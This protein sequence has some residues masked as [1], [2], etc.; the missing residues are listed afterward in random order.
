MSKNSRIQKINI[1]GEGKVGFTAIDAED[2]VAFV[3]GSRVDTDSII[4]ATT[5][6]TTLQ[7]SADSTIPLNLDFANGP[8]LKTEA[9]YIKYYTSTS[10]PTNNDDID[11]FFQIGCHWYNKTTDRMFYCADNRSDIAAWKP[12]RKTFSGS[13]DPNTVVT[14]YL[15]DDYY[16]TVGL[17]WYKCISA[18]SG[19]NWVAT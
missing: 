15:G 9:R 8:V 1:P 5:P 14:G 18:P 4:S 13:G 11:K 12:Y 17:Q 7:F 10:N 16:D 19:S 2:I 3:S 6:W